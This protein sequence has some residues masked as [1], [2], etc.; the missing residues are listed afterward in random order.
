[1]YGKAFP[2]PGEGFIP[3]PSDGLVFFAPCRRADKFSVASP[4][5]ISA[6]PAASR[7]DYIKEASL[8]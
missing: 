6:P 2:P 5:Y 3:W 1:M 7:W 4:R 8:A